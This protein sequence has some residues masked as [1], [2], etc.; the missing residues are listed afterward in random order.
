MIADLREED[1]AWL[2]AIE[3]KTFNHGLRDI[4]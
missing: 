4:S 1:S 3:E 2:N